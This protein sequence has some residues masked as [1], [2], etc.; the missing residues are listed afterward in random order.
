MAVLILLLFTLN[1][2]L[3]LLKILLSLLF[4]TARHSETSE[5]LPSL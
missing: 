1:A 2:Y 4:K 5:I 3:D